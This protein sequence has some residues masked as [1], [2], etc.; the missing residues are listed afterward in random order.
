MTPSVLCRA[1][2][3]VM[4]PR[5]DTNQIRIRMYCGYTSCCEYGRTQGEMWTPEWWEA[6]EPY[7]ERECIGGP[8]DGQRWNLEGKPMLLVARDAGG[9][10]VAAPVNDES[11]ANAPMR[12][13]S[14]GCYRPDGSA[15]RW[16]PR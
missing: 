9:A 7:R 13:A 2:G 6:T 3:A 10:H 12:A 11:D 16:V 15:L 14:L 8:M 1:C 4:S 5:P